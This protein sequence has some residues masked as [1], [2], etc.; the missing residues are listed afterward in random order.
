MMI[1]TSYPKQKKRELENNPTERPMFSFRFFQ[2]FRYSSHLRLVCFFLV[3]F[4]VPVA[5]LG[6]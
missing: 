5:L 2:F 3:F 4:L 6:I 1:I